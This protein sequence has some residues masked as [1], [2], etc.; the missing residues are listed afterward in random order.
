MIQEN[1]NK[2]DIAFTFDIQMNDK[3]E[4][5]KS[6]AIK[7]EFLDENIFKFSSSNLLKK[8][9]FDLSS[10]IP[11]DLKLSPNEIYDFEDK[12]EKINIIKKNDA[13]FK[14]SINKNPFFIDVLNSEGE[15]IVGLNQK[16]CFSSSPYPAFDFNFDHEFLFGIPERAEH[17][18]LPDSTKENPYRL[19]NLDR[20][21]YDI[22]NK[23]GVYGSVPLLI[24]Q[25]PKKTVGIF[26]RN[27]SL[28]YIDIMKNKNKSNCLWLSECGDLEF[29]IIPALSQQDLFLKLGKLLGFAPL[30]PYFSFG[31]HHSKWSFKDQKDVEEIDKNFDLHKIPYDV[32]YL[33]IDYTD[34]KKYFTYD[35]ALFPKPLEM[36]DKLAAKG[37]KLVTIIDPHI[38]K[39]EGYFLYEEAVKNNYFVKDEKNIDFEGKCWPGDSH[40]LDYLNKD[41]EKYWASLYAYDKFIYSK[42]NVHIWN[43]MNEPSVFGGPDSTM[44]KTLIHKVQDQNGELMDVEHKE[45]HNLY[46]YCQARGTYTGLIERNEDKNQRAFLLTRSFFAGIQKY[47]AVWTGDTLSTWPYLKITL[48][49]LLS[50]SVSGISF[51]GGD[52][53]GFQIDPT[54]DLHIRWFQSAVIYPFFRGHS[55]KDAMRREPWLYD[56]KIKEMIRDAILLRYEILPYIYTVFYEYTKTN[57]PVLRPLWYLLPEK[58]DI[59]GVDDQ[60]LLG[61]CILSSPILEEK[62]TS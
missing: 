40:W 27:A 53:G 30:P 8:S 16:N 12:A 61:D 3:I 41:V 18:L 15:K 10:I 50:L 47:S 56:K 43:D 26:W 33:D 37:R 11:L 29:Y 44:P 51:C 14:L 9:K 2:K 20:F 36:I 48:P 34:E 39:Q 32:I 28:T 38:K 62:Q 17:F 31:Y 52:I 42:D 5:E 49:M 13:S 45:V 7:L 21:G 55:A 59:Y 19:F 35:L 23:S 60:M 4:Q 1:F 57:I 25:Y 22:Y 6:F 46:G 58:L 24:A 54:D